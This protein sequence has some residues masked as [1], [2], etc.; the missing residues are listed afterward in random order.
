MTTVSNLAGSR[1]FLSSNVKSAKN[2]SSTTSAN[3]AQN[4]KY[5]Q[6]QKI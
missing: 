2:I 3:S 4:D 5:S 6:K 1:Y